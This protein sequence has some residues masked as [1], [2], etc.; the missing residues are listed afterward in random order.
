MPVSQHHPFLRGQALEPDRA[1][2]VKF[3]RANPDLRP[4]TVLKAVSEA[5]GGID[6]DRARIDFVD[7]PAGVLEIL[8]D[9]SVRVLRSV[10]ADVIDGGI[11]IVDDP[12]CEYRCEEFLVVIVFACF[13]DGIIER[14]R[15][16][17]PSKL[18]A[19]IELD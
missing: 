14:T 19:G 15:T 1:A 17:A 16:C 13:L 10:S 4:E 11:Q 9:D 7:K 6:D 18:N 3:I 12:N 2:R 5:G 8:C